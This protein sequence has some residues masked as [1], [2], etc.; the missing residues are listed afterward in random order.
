MPSPFPGVDPFIEATGRWIGFHNI[1]ITHYSESLNASLPPNYA[2]V[3]EERVEL[4]DFSSDLPRHQ[5][6]PDIGV[7]RDLDAPRGSG[8]TAMA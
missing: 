6:V 3:V 5:R 7:V 2:A 1:L 8:G 4:V